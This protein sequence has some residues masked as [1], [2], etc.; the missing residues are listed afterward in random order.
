LIDQYGLI[1]KL[2]ADDEDRDERRVAIYWARKRRCEFVFEIL[3]GPVLNLQRFYVPYISIFKSLALFM[4][5]D[6]YNRKLWYMR[7]EDAKRCNEGIDP[8]LGYEEGERPYDQL[9]DRAM[10]YPIKHRT[11]G[12]PIQDTVSIKPCLFAKI[13]KYSVPRQELADS[14]LIIT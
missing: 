8:Q 10:P 13:I 5:N 3:H 2:Y 4:T 11:I 1:V 6:N 12:M 9:G 14:L 7:V